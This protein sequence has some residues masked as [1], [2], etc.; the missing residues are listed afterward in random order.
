M[1]SR[2][3]YAI[4]CFILS[5]VLLF[6]AVPVLTHRLYPKIQA[7][8]VIRPMDKGEQLTREDIA[9]IEIGVLELPKGIELTAEDVLGRYAA[10]ELVKDDVLFSDK[11]SQ[12]PLDGDLPKNILPEGN[13]SQLITMKMITG[14]EYPVP[15]TGD[16]VKLN[17]FQGKLIDIPQ[18]QFVRVLS[19]ILPEE[20]SE[21]V[22][23]T[24]SLNE[25]QQKYIR[26]HKEDVFYTSV[27]VRSNEELA[28][29]LLAEQK[30]YFEEG[31]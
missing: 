7:V 25:E 6:I 28:E 18:L 22:T 15:Q 14:S 9:P 16:V 5:V 21:N 4:G 29:K 17:G 1:R 31:N 3:Y 10:V 20:D 19:V 2:L 13:I 26:R 24:V 23:V 8:K 30:L 11:L 12:L 27:I